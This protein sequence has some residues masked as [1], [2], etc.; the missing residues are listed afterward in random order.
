MDRLSTLIA[1]SEIEEV[2][3]R[4]ARAVDRRDW[5]ALR[6]CFHEGAI[7]HHGDFRGGPEAFIAWVSERHASIPFS[8]HFLGNCMIE[9]LNDA[10][11][12]VETYFIAIQRRETTLASGSGGVERTD[13]EVFGRYC[14]RF[15]LRDGAWRIAYR[16]VAYD[17]TRTQPSSDHLRRLVGVIGRRDQSDAVFR[18]RTAAE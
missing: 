1:K 14:D 16:Q 5:Q 10:T 9:F 18:L 8:M 2:M 11:A 4:Y 7:D 15:E 12:A 6:G 13:H 3:F 17:S